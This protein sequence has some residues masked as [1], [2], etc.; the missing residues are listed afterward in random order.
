MQDTKVLLQQ[1]RERLII[2]RVAN[3]REFD[4]SKYR[5]DIPSSS[6]SGG[7]KFRLGQPITVNWKAPKGHSR[8]DWIGIYRVC[9][10][11]L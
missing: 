4:A 7:L 5:L 1:S 6:S 9:L 10:L 3:E 11:S 8:K 2:T